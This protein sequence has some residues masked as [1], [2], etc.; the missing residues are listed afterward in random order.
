MWL[1]SLDNYHIFLGWLQN[2]QWVVLEFLEV[3]EAVH[4]CVWAFQA[5]HYY[6]SYLIPYFELKEKTNDCFF[7]EPQK[8]F[9]TK[10]EKPWKY[11]CF[12]IEEQ[13]KKGRETN[14]KICDDQKEVWTYQVQSKEKGSKSLC[15]RKRKMKNAQRA[16][17]KQKKKDLIGEG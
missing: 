7:I 15:K 14:E 6:I 12:E 2:K 4:K 17:W 3:I 1:C 13:H 9:I 5:T 10:P 16:K 11:P 8:T